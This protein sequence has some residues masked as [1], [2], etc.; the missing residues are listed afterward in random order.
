MSQRT[1]SIMQPY[2]IPYAGYFR[3][4]AAAD[5][6]VIYDCVQFNRRGWMHRNILHDRVG[7]RKW[8]TLPL[9]KASRDVLIRDLTFRETAEAEFAEAMRRFPIFTPSGLKH[10]GTVID[11]LTD[12]DV[13]PTIY[14]ERLLKWAVTALGMQWNVVRSSE[15]RIAPHLHGQERILAIASQVGATRYVNA[16]GGVELYEKAAFDA[17]GIELSFLPPY[18]GPTTSI[19]ERILLEDRARLSSEIRLN[20]ML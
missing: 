15:L 5:L 13:Q 20:L 18:E 1:V 2:F 7:K 16:P 8:V 4:F 14:I 11:L 12:F 19:L 9:Q 6:F 3:L 10:N 17:A